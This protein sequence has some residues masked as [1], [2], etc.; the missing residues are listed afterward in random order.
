MGVFDVLTNTTNH[1]SYH[2]NRLLT[3]ICQ[4][5]NRLLNCKRESMSHLQDYGLPDFGEVYRSLPGGLSDFARNIEHVI[6]CYEPRVTYVACTDYELDSQSGQ[7]KIDIEIMTVQQEHSNL[8]TRLSPVNQMT[9][10]A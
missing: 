3:S 5:L 6:E 8:V 4:H 9:V 10:S 7:V 1:A 2:D